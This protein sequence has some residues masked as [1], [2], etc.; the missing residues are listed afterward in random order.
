MV[1]HFA[2]SLYLFS[3]F[4]YWTVIKY[5]SP[6]LTAVF[7]DPPRKVQIPLCKQIQ[8]RT[9]AYMLIAQNIVVRILTAFSIC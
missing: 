9:P 2:D 4:L 3:T 5:Q 7:N 1:M 8:D 6:D